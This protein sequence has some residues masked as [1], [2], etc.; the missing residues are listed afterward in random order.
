MLLP[1]MQR[2]DRQTGAKRHLPTGLLTGL[3]TALCTKS[4]P[5]N[6]HRLTHNALPKN[7]IYGWVRGP[8][9]THRLL[10]TRIPMCGGSCPQTLFIGRNNLAITRNSVADRA[11]SVENPPSGE[12]ISCSSARISLW[13]PNEINA[14]ARSRTLTMASPVWPK[15][16]YSR[17]PA[18]WGAASDSETDGP[19]NTRLH[20]PLFF[21]EIPVTKKDRNN[22]GRIIRTRCAA[23][24]VG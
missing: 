8:Q 22:Q 3:F 15:R 10:C 4:R 19:W 9:N 13:R 2:N 6:T 5:H 23:A 12:P 1:H 11:H 7:S 16:C 20:G 17:P 24:L 14:L 18:P 21:P